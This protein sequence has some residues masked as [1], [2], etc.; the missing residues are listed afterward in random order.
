MQ[1]FSFVSN[2]ISNTCCPG[3][4]CNSNYSFCICPCFLSLSHHCV[5]ALF[6][7]IT[8]SLYDD[9]AGASHLSPGYLCRVEAL[10]II[11]TEFLWLNSVQLMMS[12]PSVE[13]DRVCSQ[14]F[15]LLFVCC[16]TVYSFVCESTIC[17][18][19][20]LSY[21]CVVVDDTAHVL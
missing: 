18:T 20:F 14:L 13:W 5:L 2:I 16:Y 10:L 12:E 15:L 19:Y 1:F 17:L 8:A 3:T 7:N 6:F 21:N 11:C 4:P 9:I